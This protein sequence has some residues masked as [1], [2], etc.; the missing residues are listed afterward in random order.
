MKTDPQ[1]MEEIRRLLDEYT[2][3]CNANLGT[4][5]SSKTYIDYASMF[6]RWVDDKF[7]PGARRGR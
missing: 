7:T 5:I 2:K 6:V 3:V 1:T 4:P